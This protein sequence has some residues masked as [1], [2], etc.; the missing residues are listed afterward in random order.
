LLYQKYQKVKTKMQSHILELKIK[1]ELINWELFNLQVLMNYL[2]SMESNWDSKILVLI[3]LFYKF[4]LDLCLLFNKEVMLRH[5][6]W[7]KLK[8]KDQKSNFCIK[9]SKHLVFISFKNNS[10]LDLSS[11]IFTSFEL[12]EIQMKEW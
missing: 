7:T 10:N 11:I 9:K 4:F 3:H 12:N 1:V 8:N 5:W 6:I 2:K